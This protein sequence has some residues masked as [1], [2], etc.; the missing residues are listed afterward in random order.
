MAKRN[1]SALKAHR[2]NIKR[3]EHNRAA[4][5]E[6]PHRPEGHPQGPRRRK[7]DDAKALLSATPSLVDKMAAK[8][9]I[10]RNTAA[11]Y[12]SRLV[13]ARLGQDGLS[14]ATGPGRRALLAAGARTAPRP[15]A[16][17]GS[18]ARRPTTSAPGRRRAPLE[19][20]GAAR[21]SGRSCARRRADLPE[22][23]R[24]PAR[25]PRTAPRP[26]AAPRA[27]LPLSDSLDRAR[28]RPPGSSTGIT[29][30]RTWRR[31]D[32]RLAGR[33]EH[34]LLDLAARIAPQAQPGGVRAAARRRRRLDR[35]SRRARGGASDPARPRR[36]AS[37]S[38]PQSTTA[39]CASSS[40]DAPPIAVERRRSR[41]PAS[42]SARV[43]RD[44]PRTPR[45]ASTP[46]RV[47]S[48]PASAPSSSLRACGVSRRSASCTTTSRRGAIIGS[49]RAAARIAA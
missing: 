21:A 27:A 9:I 13:T 49:V 11:R 14:R 15:G 1:K 44:R 22:H 35:A 46:W 20:P 48:A 2:Q 45:P 42:S 4:A 41:T 3:R 47:A 6:A 39:A 17:A 38:A 25:R 24:P 33:V 26:R 43:A 19:A 34:Q 8:G 31:G 10:H 12:K 37:S 40:F 29:R 32:R 28:S 7:V 36:R 5:L 16:R 18:A 30:S 23:H